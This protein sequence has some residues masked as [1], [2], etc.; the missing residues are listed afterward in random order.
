[1]VHAPRQSF[2][3]VLGLEDERQHLLGGEGLGDAVDHRSDERVGEIADDD[4]D[5]RRRPPTQRPGD[6]VA[7]V[8]EVLGCRAHAGDRRPVD[9]VRFGRVEGA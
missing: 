5:G 4:P 8:T 1:V 7:T 6:V 9:E 3:V 2:G